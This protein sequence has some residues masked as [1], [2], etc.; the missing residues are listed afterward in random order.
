MKNIISVLIL[1]VISIGLVTDLN[2]QQNTPAEY[3][4]SLTDG[5]KLAFVN[6]A[7]TAVS[8]MKSFHM[9]EV[10]MQYGHDPYWRE[11]Y[12]VER[13]YQILDQHLA[14]GVGYNIDIIAQAMDALYANFDNVRIPIIEALRIVSTA[15]DGEQQKANVL[16][17]K[18]QRQYRPED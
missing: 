10:K 8:R 9:E 13:F 18:A 12:F 14:E 7:Y 11:P 15:Q 2:A 16:L 3:W 4:D 17:L 5:E 1:I 6:G